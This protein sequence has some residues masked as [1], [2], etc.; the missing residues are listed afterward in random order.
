L[1]GAEFINIDQQAQLSDITDGHYSLKD[2]K[3]FLTLGKESQGKLSLRLQVVKDSLVDGKEIKVTLGDQVLIVPIKIEKSDEASTN[4]EET[5]VSEKKTGTL[6]DK[7][8]GL[9]L[10][11]TQFL[12]NAQSFP[13]TIVENSKSSDPNTDGLADMGFSDVPGAHDGRIWTD[14]TVRHDLGSLSEDQFEVTLSALA[15]SAPA[16]A[17]YQI[18]ADTV[19]T[20]DVSGSMTRVDSPGGRSRIALL[21]DAINEAI[22]ILQDAN[23]L[24]RVAVVAY[25]GAT[26]GYARVGKCSF[27][28]TL[29]FY[30][31]FFLYHGNIFPSQCSGKA[32]PNSGGQVKADRLS[33]TGSTP[34][35]W[36]IREASRI[37]EQVSDR[38]VEVPV[39]D[40]D[41]NPEAPVTVTRRPNLILMTD[42]EP[43][44]GRPD[45]A[46]DSS[47]P[48][49]VGPNGGQIVASTGD[50]YGDGSYGEQGL[51]V[52]TALTAAYRERTVFNHFFPQGQVQ[53]TAPTQPG[54]DVGFL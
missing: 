15:Q 26:G 53:G 34:T 16:R 51:A 2:N 12:P 49:P 31:W 7:E 22:D 50:F 30:E 35:Q 9:N 21:V 11:S 25:G 38:L 13:W 54:A 27:I 29:R 43:T 1:E 5:S 40:E 47:S 52:M 20:I 41:G 33:V 46:F 8:R 36:G 32:S 24:N 44:M 39:T 18:P 6:T 48:V 14:K 4:A 42:G 37:L 23:P 10:G 17:G 3:I 28:R 19:F 45:F